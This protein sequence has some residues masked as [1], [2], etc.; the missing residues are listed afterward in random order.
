MRHTVRFLWVPQTLLWTLLFFCSLPTWA[1]QTLTIHKVG[2]GEAS[3]GTMD[4]GAFCGGDCRDITVNFPDNADVLLL[5]KFAPNAKFVKWI[6]D[7]GGKSPI[8]RL[9]M[10]RPRTV[11]AVIEARY[12]IPACPSDASVKDFLL[13]SPIELSQIDHI[14]PLGQVSPMS[15][16][17]FPVAHLYFSLQTSSPTPWA[18]VQSPADAYITNVYVSNDGGFKN[19]DVT[20]QTCRE[21]MLHLDHITDFS[22]DLLQAMGAPS[23]C[24][25]DNSFC[26]YTNLKV[27]VKLGQFL[28]TA[29]KV[30][31]NLDVEAY[32]L[33]ATPLSY[34]NSKRVE[35]AY[36]NI[37]CPLD[38][39]TD[40]DAYGT[41]TSLYGKIIPSAMGSC[42]VVAQDLVNTVQGAWY[43]HNMAMSFNEGNILALV[44]DSENFSQ[45]LFSI[46]S[47]IGG[48]SS[49]PATYYHYTVESSG[50]KNRNFSDVTSGANPPI[51]C[52][53]GL[54]NGSP[55]SD[56]I[57][58]M[59]MTTSTTLLAKVVHRSSP[60]LD[61]D[62]AQTEGIWVTGASPG[63]L[64]SDSYGTVEQYDR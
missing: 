4:P 7:C 46:G 44:H 21:F 1:D 10:D 60:A 53:D 12:D 5:T 2:S 16:H 62:Q 47:L 14:K 19:Y 17:T 32:D 22:T 51:Y 54:T 6:G 61:C 64:T 25:P 57:L 50:L 33:R 38:Y 37:V 23:G 24:L 49:L 8:C 35:A 30:G 36:R 28:G 27:P 52:F 20:M 11:T 41:K 48:A 55:V 13:Q 45:P 63:T 26:A 9:K 39:F 58:L 29:G 42:G 31:P 3:I 40:S 59:Q 34:I 18:Y 15:G 43:K 56:T